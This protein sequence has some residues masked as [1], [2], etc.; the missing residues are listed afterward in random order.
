MTL[1]EFI[2]R[3]LKRH[4]LQQKDLH[5]FIASQTG[6]LPAT[7]KEQL[8]QA[9]TT[10]TDPETKKRIRE[11]A[12]YAPRFPFLADVIEF[13][14]SHGEVDTASR[15]QHCYSNQTFDLGFILD[16]H[17]R[18]DSMHERIGWLYFPPPPVPYFTKQLQP[19][20]ERWARELLAG[21]HELYGHSLALYN[22][23]ATSAAHRDIRRAV[24]LTLARA[25]NLYGDYTEAFL[26][27]DRFIASYNLA[28]RTGYAFSEDDR[29]DYIEAL[30]LRAIAKSQ[31][32]FY[33]PREASAEMFGFA[34]AELKRLE[35]EQRL[36]PPNVMDMRVHLATRQLRMLTRDA[37]IPGSLLRDPTE[38][39]Q[40]ELYGLCVELSASVPADQ[41][42]VFWDTL[43][44][45]ACVVLLDLEAARIHHATAVA[46]FEEDN[47]LGKVDAP[48]NLPPALQDSKRRVN[49]TRLLTTIAYIQCALVRERPHDEYY[50]Q[51]AFRAMGQVVES[52]QPM[53]LQS[54]GASVALLERFLSWCRFGGLESPSR[55]TLRSTL[56]SRMFQSE[57]LMLD[58]VAMERPETFFTLSGSDAE[59]QVQALYQAYALSFMRKRVRL[60]RRRRPKGTPRPVIDEAPNRRGP[61]A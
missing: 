26:I 10:P 42:F 19:R 32:S 35:N 16:L 25:C 48:E 3:C 43:C 5:E 53:R 15:L 38:W 52:L 36:S 47:R 46:A 20:L 56:D 61:P 51:N 34:W 59:E 58:R 6:Q 30:Q 23:F 54:T 57:T 31:V 11:K 50:L 18:G 27:T 55:S 44:R 45:Y 41:R 1:G 9:T 12:V 24:C 60:E 13:F 14:R 28:E 8:R 33:N 4:G 40:H 7:V 37:C 21:D 39:R 22:Q 17:P 49:N 2:K 29:T